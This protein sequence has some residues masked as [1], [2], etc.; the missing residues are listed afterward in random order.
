MS[1][2]VHQ[3]YGSTTILINCWENLERAN[4]FLS[5]VSTAN[6]L[7]QASDKA[8]LWARD[9]LDA[10]ARARPQRTGSRA[11]PIIRCMHHA[12]GDEPSATG[13]WLEDVPYNHLWRV[14]KVI[15]KL[16]TT[17]AVAVRWN[18]GFIFWLLRVAV[19]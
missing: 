14:S 18:E 4:Y 12:M 9:L 15:R 2:V 16:G 8:T 1:K 13:T 5:I 19:L 10:V 7:V 11:H 17:Q 6:A 3:L